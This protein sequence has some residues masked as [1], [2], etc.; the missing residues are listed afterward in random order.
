MMCMEC[1]IL[2]H[3]SI[4]KMPFITCIYKCL[5][6]SGFTG[7]PRF[8]K[9][10]VTCVYFLIKQVLYFMCLCYILK[11]FLMLSAFLTSLNQFLETKSNILHL[12]TK[13]NISC[14]EIYNYVPKLMG[15]K[16][17]TICN[18]EH[19]LYTKTETHLLQNNNNIDNTGII[20][21]SYIITSIPLRLFQHFECIHCNSMCQNL[22]ITFNRSV[23]H[24]FT[25]KLNIDHNV[26]G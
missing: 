13:S 22:K 7:S 15:N 4:F 3:S 17:S 8:M 6:C 1:N 25:L 9:H 12:G 24:S 10:N 11:I 14:S 23:V 21:F 18:Y 26:R 20:I 16:K 19:N 2:I 5:E